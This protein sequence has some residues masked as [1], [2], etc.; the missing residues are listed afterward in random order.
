MLEL[1]REGAV[2]RRR[3]IESLNALGEHLRAAELAHII[4]NYTLTVEG[5]ADTV[6]A[7]VTRGGAAVEAFDSETLE[8]RDW[9][10]LYMVGEA[11]DVD[12]RC[13]GYNLHWAFAS[14]LRAG[15]SAAK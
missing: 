14:G 1:E 7:Q 15:R 9:D 6:N 13:G 5:A 3:P 2:L 4:K 10:G 11:L 12:G 8:C